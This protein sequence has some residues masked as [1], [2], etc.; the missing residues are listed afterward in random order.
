MGRRW[1]VEWGVCRLRAIKGSELRESVPEGLSTQR[2]ERT[3]ASKSVRLGDDRRQSVKQPVRLPVERLVDGRVGDEHPLVSVVNGRKSWSD[4]VREL[5]RRDGTHIWK[6]S[7][8]RIRRRSRNLTAAR[9]SVNASDSSAGSVSSACSNTRSYTE[10]GKGTS[11]S[12]IG[13]FVE[14][15]SRKE[16][17]KLGQ[18]DGPQVAEYV[19]S[20]PADQHPQAEVH[21][22]VHARGQSRRPQH[23]D[24]VLLDRG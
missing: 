9:T 21:L 3:N 10:Q 18:D 19:R 24:Q 14:E 11:R 4:R 13:L 8:C 2:E 17:H 7:S 20:H 12:Q 22:R 6:S 23:L 15:V 5:K 16:T 1:E